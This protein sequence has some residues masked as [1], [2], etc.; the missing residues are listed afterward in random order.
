MSLPNYENRPHPLTPTGLSMFKSKELG[1]LAGALSKAQAELESAKKDQSG[2][3]YNYSSL[4]D[5][6]NTAKPILAKHSL[7]V[8]QLLTNDGMGHPAVTTM[9]MHSSGQYLESTVSLPAIDMKGCNPV[10]GAGATISYLRRYAYQA[11]L[12]MASEDNDAHSEGFNNK[13]I[14]SSKPTEKKTQPFRKKNVVKN[15]E[16]DDF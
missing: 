11:I 1:E 13:P 7:S 12:G 15:E 4:G 8:S 16:K 3:G 5:V 14:T 9:L 10:Q 6:I 2:Y